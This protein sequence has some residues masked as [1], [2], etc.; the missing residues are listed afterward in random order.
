MP[1]STNQSKT[2]MMLL[3]LLSNK[4]EFKAKKELIAARSGTTQWE[5]EQSEKEGGTIRYL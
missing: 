3:I 2:D 1:G 4:S 5:K